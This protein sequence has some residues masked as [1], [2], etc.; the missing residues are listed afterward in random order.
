[1]GRTALASLETGISN[2]LVA[3]VYHFW[4]LAPARMHCSKL[5]GQV[6]LRAHMAGWTSALVKFFLVCG[7][8]F[9]WLGL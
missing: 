4:Y 3:Y 2:K 6:V 7:D 9:R 8:H 5:E 1:M